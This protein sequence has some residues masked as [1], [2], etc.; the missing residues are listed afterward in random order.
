MNTRRANVR[1]VEEENVNQGIPQGNQAPLDEQAPIDSTNVTQEKFRETMI[2]QAMTAQ[3]Q[4]VTTQSQAITTQPQAITAQ[5]NRD[6]GPNVNFVASRLRD[7]TRM[8]PPMFFS[9]KVGED[10]QEL[11]KEI[12]KIVTAMG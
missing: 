7:F 11:L 2:T 10:P 4:A 12:Y 6:V 5:A 9:S 1:R 8:N 3:A